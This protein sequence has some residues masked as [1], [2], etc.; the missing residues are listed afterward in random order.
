MKR[1]R[2]AADANA[3][4]Q[5]AH[6]RARRAREAELQHLI[7]AT[8]Q[9]EAKDRAA[10]TELVAQRKAL[11]Y[12]PTFATLLARLPARRPVARFGASELQGAFIT[13]SAALFCLARLCKKRV[14]KNSGGAKTTTLI[15]CNTV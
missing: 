14:N 7:I 9:K 12:E 2:A 8:R 15:C 11:H 10:A 6:Q 3:R 5:E 13:F 4:S 1:E